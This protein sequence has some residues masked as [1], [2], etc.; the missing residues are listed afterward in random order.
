MILATSGDEDAGG[1][2]EGDGSVGAALGV[3]DILVVCMKTND[4]DAGSL[5]A[6]YDLGDGLRDFRLV[7]KADDDC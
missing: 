4:S 3:Q 2:V 7:L 5:E 6:A 1:N